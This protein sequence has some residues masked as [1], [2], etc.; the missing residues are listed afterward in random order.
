MKFSVSNCCYVADSFAAMA[1]LP[2]EFGIE[3]QIEFGTEYYWKTNLAKVMKD[4]TG[5]LSIHGQFVDIDLGSDNMDEQEIMDYYKW[6]FDMYNKYDATHF[7][8]HPDGKIL[9]PATPE[10]VAAMRSRALE[11]IGRL[12]DLA[13]Q[14]DVN[15]LVENLRPRGYGLVFDTEEFID[16]FRQLPDVDCLI[17]TGHMYLS[18]WD[19]HRVLSALGSRIK[20]YHINDN[21]GVEDQHLPV[22]KGCIDWGAFFD[23]YKKYTPDAEMVLEYKGV[24]V[25]DLVASARLIR[26]LLR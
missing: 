22:G 26:A 5:E 17:D 21:Y 7:V 8:I 2:P 16:L 18:G 15:L 12:S 20:S 6:A 11:R 9:A 23:D 10:Q 1:A 19:F 3:I 25:P 4:R 13:K 14:M 24:T